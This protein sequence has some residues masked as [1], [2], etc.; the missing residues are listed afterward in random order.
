MVRQNYKFNIKWFK[1]VFK[2]IELIHFTSE[3]SFKDKFIKHFNVIKH[4]KII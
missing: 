1:I 3:M 2:K 4:N